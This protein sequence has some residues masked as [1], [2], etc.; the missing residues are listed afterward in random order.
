MY[1]IAAQNKF[2]FPST[3]GP[4]MVEQLFDLPLKSSNGCDLDTIART[5]NNDLKTMTQESFVE[6]ATTNPQKAYL[7][8][9]LEIVKDVIKTKQAENAIQLS[10]TKRAQER[11]KLLDIIGAKKDEALTK[12]SLEDLEKKL[13]E[14]D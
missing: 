2:R 14:L 12:A 1:K 5:V 7:E 3:R 9:S 8:T 13:A 4:L 6:D 11:R 10:K